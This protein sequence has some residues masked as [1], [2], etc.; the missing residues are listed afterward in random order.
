MRFRFM[1]LEDEEAVL[2]RVVDAVGSRAL[3]PDPTLAR[4]AESEN[5]CSA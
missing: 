1:T 5:S 4:L 3:P 2:R